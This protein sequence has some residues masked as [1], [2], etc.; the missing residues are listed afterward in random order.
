[1]KLP[2]YSIISYMILLQHMVN[3]YFNS[4][5]KKKIEQY[6]YNQKSTRPYTKT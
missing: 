2:Y 1:M 6:T 3:S 5:Q 4:E